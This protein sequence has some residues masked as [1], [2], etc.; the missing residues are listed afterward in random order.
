MRCKF[1]SVI[2]KEKNMTKNCDLTQKFSFFIFSVFPYM[3]YGKIM[4]NVN[5]KWIEKNNYFIS[6]GEEVQ[7]IILYRCSTLKWK[8]T[9]FD[10]QDSL[11]YLI[12]FSSTMNAEY[13]Y[14]G[15]IVINCNPLAAV[16]QQPVLSLWKVSL[17]PFPIQYYY[18]Y[19]PYNFTLHTLVL[20]LLIEVEDWNYSLW[21][22]FSSANILLWTFLSVKLETKIKYDN[23]SLTTMYPTDIGFKNWIERANTFKS[24]ILTIRNPLDL[25]FWV[26]FN[27]TK[28]HPQIKF[29]MFLLKG[30][31]KWMPSLNL[32]NK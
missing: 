22:N 11:K 19:Y 26:I 6:S 24:N 18:Y 10:T 31:I 5:T 25:Y 7:W 23:I 15:F 14:Y 28:W 32:L 8:I 3:K 20:I 27:L 17:V 30:L 13:K 1:F 9:S 21:R 16:L 4:A 2:E 29:D 12:A